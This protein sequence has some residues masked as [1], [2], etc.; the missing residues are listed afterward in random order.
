LTLKDLLDHALQAGWWKDRDMFHD[1]RH[2]YSGEEG[3]GGDGSNGGYDDDDS[4]AS[5]CSYNSA[6]PSP[7][8]GEGQDDRAANGSHDESESEAEGEQPVSVVTWQ[9]TGEM[10]HSD[11]PVTPVCPSALYGAHWEWEDGSRGSENWMPYDGSM[12][13][14]LEAVHGAARSRQGI[15]VCEALVHG[16]LY[17]YNVVH[18]KQSPD[19]L[20]PTIVVYGPLDMFQLNVR[21]G[22]KR[23]M[24]RRGPYEF[25]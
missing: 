1:R 20:S 14:H 10:R 7:G 5:P 16:K 9:L 6:S 17:E 18:R 22:W 12:A 19:F 23:R 13:R 3:Q 11:V 8:H 24:R 21:T 25:V 4:L 2:D 15:G